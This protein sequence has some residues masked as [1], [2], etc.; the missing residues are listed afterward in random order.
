MVTL[1]VSGGRLGVI[2]RT[3]LVLAE[4]D[5]ERYLVALAGE[6]QWPHDQPQAGVYE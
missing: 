3:N 2:R 5:S 4:H 6:S 1:E